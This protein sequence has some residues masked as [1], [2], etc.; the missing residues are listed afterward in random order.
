M[1]EM[2]EFESNDIEINLRE[3]IIA[4]KRNLLKIILVVALCAGSRQWIY[5]FLCG[6]DLFFH[7]GVVY[8]GK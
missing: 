2:Y 6:T 7:S 1:K 5:D 4:L 3:I 8:S